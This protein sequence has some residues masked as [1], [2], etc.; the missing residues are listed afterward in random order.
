MTVA[1]LVLE[2]VSKR[3]GDVQ[4]LAPLDLEISQGEFVGVLGPSGCG[5][6]TLLRCL[7]GLEQPDTGRIRFGDRTVVDVEARIQEP[8]QRRGL[9]MVFQDLALWPHLT[10]F[11]NVAYTLRARKD[12][13][14]LEDR[15]HDALAKV[16]LPIHAARYPHQLSGGQQQRVAFARAVVDRP[17]V[18]LM[19]EP[20]SALDAALRVDLRAELTALTRALGLTAVYVTHDQ[21]EAMSMADRIL[22]MQDGFVRQD[23]APETVYQRPTTRFVADFIGRLNALDRP[24]SSVTP[25]GAVAAVGSTGGRAGDDVSSSPV[26][27]NGSGQLDAAAR[28]V[29]DEV[30]NADVGGHGNAD[31]AAAVPPPVAADGEAADVYAR[32][33]ASTEVALTGTGV[34]GVRPEKVRL[35]ANGREMVALPA[36]VELVS[37]LG[38]HYELRCRLALADQ[39]WVV[40]S[41]HRVE[42]G[43]RVL[44]HLAPDDLI[45]TEQ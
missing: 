2:G 29:A 20:L 8:P 37:Y 1:R 13:V 45:V 27:A 25:V 38:D 40:M 12:T 21:H 44:L 18:L 28:R 31:V 35:S 16:Q 32:I 23:G 3:F 42:V 19:D 5:K 26:G 36:E 9:G 39:P 41:D 6:T 24:L 17:S 22:V 14:D 30:D 7:A 43:E 15:V 11:E 34:A 10:V 33:D 4:A